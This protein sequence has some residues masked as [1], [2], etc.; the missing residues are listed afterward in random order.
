MSLQSYERGDTF[1]VTVEWKSGS[2]Y[3]DPL[4]NAS[5]LTIYKPDGTKLLDN[6]SGSRLATGIYYYYPSTSTTEQL[7]IY[8]IEWNGKFTYGNPYGN[9]PNYQRECVIIDKV[10]Q[11]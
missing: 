5:H 7:G 6:V 2:T 10:I 8:I 11:S 1:K 9:L 4:N 3:T